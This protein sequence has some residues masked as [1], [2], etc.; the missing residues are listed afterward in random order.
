[1]ILSLQRMWIADRLCRVIN[2]ATFQSLD[3]QSSIENDTV[4]I[5][6]EAIIVGLPDLLVG[7]DWPERHFGIAQTPFR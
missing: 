5:S 2:L 1:M 3:N 6:P 4:R 7:G